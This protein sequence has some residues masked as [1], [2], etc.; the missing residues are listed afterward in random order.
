[1]TDTVTVPRWALE[2]VLEFAIADVD[3]FETIA[4][5]AKWEP[6]YKALK[7]ALDTKELMRIGDKVQTDFSGKITDHVVVATRATRSCQ[8]GLMVQVKPP[9]PKSGGGDAWIDAGWFTS[10][11]PEPWNKGGDDDECIERS[12]AKGVKR[13]QQGF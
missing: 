3:C 13:I 5:K 9:I 2:F 4:E 6:A 8:S 1:M 11:G 7:R 12:E 10:P